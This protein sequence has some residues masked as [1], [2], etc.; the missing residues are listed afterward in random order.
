[1][2]LISLSF[3]RHDSDEADVLQ[4][5][6]SIDGKK[7]GKDA[8]KAHMLCLSTGPF[9]IAMKANRTSKKAGKKQNYFFCIST[10]QHFTAPSP[11]LVTMICPPQLPQIYIFP[12]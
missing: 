11:P 1:L 3:A 12:S 9:M 4:A 6:F 2:D 10:P 5:G 8:K 7:E